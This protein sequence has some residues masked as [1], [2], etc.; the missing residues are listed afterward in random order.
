M[1][2]MKTR[3]SENIHCAGEYSFADE[4]TVRRNQAQPRLDQLA[5]ECSCIQGTGAS[6]SRGN[7]RQIDPV[8]CAFR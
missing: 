7:I 4:F 1:A 8:I 2:L 3:E 6:I 5:A